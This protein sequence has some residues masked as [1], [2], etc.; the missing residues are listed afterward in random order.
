MEAFCVS[1]K[2]VD[3]SPECTKMHNVSAMLCKDSVA[4]IEDSMDKHKK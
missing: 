3:E 1:L 2:T 4:K